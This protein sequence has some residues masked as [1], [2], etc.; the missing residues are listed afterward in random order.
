MRTAPLL[1]VFAL[2]QA[3][4]PAAASGQ[5]PPPAGGPAAAGQAMTRAAGMPLGDGTL[6]PGMLTVRIVRGDFSNNAADQDVTIEVSGAAP[7]TARTGADG[8]AQFAHLAVGASVRASAT[9]DGQPLTSEAFTMPAESGV[10]LLLVAGDGPATA[11]GPAPAARA[12]SSEAAPLVGAAAGA[13]S[14]PS[15][16]AS[17]QPGGSG[18]DAS[19]GLVVIRGVLAGASVLSIGLLV[20]RRRRSVRRPAAQDD[21][22]D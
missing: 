16:A 17:A 12:S 10:R 6:A 8:R 21:D 15:P 18:E 9:V 2:A 19:G 1:V 7:Q 22:H 5:A 14:P 13:A 3:L 4:A 11:T 20:L